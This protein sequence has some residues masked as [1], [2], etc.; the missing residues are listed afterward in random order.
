M[1]IKT[2]Q[3]FLIKYIRKAKVRNFLKAVFLMLSAV[4]LEALFLKSL[5]K[6]IISIETLEFNLIIY[7]CLLA[8]LLITFTG[9]IKI[10]Q[11]KYYV[12][13]SAKIGKLICEDCLTG[14]FGDNLIKT[15]TFKSSDLINSVIVQSNYVTNGVILSG[16]NLLNYL[17]VSIGIIIVLTYNLG[18]SIIILI[19]FMLLMYF[20]I[21]KI[22]KTKYESISKLQVEYINKLTNNILFL[23]NNK[24]R[25]FLNRKNFNI[26]S[27]T[28]Y[29][30]RKY[31]DFIA[32]TKELLILPKF[33]VETIAIIILLCV[34]ILLSKN[35][36]LL[37][38]SKVG[39]L[40]FGILRILPNFQTIYYSWGQINSNSSQIDSL[41]K[42]KNKIPFEDFNF[43]GINQISKIL[44][45]KQSNLILNINRGDSIC[46]VGKSGSG[47]T[48]FLDL[49]CKLFEID[50]IFVEYL[51]L[52]GKIINSDYVKSQ[53]SYVEQDVFLPDLTVKDIIFKNSLKE[54]SLK[55][56]NYIC[57][58][59]YLKEIL[60]S[61]FWD[62]TS[63]GGSGG[64]LSGGQKQRVAIAQAL[65]WDPSILVLDE[66]TSGIDSETELKIW[67]NLL[68]IEDLILIAVT[69]NKALHSK[70]DKVIDIENLKLHNLSFKNTNDA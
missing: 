24:K 57:K 27:N 62:K 46:I 40:F 41:V 6:I 43:K 64:N 5:Q 9:L 60:S 68:K 25:V 66:A 14:Y 28:F 2:H 55:S 16:L 19:L 33:I 3:E 49:I 35:G 44:V 51:D 34:L 63:I 32:N 17:L 38:I 22:N 36:D 7:N 18:F 37:I 26:F 1:I 65:A 59:T 23:I 48:T 61:K 42:Y 67:D 58:L 12:R 45:Y 70:F 50:E 39:L 11:L 8:L 15:R 69:H 30:D 4:L 13:Y 56:K 31:R 21:A 20:L 47:K 29:L 52:N 54:I 53:I 10:I